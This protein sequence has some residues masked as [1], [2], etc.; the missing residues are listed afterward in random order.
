MSNFSKIVIIILIILSFFF[1]EEKYGKQMNS[2][3]SSIG[4]MPKIEMPNKNEETEQVKKPTDIS[5]QTNE[6]KNKTVANIYFLALDSD[7]NGILF[8]DKWWLFN[9]TIYY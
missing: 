2:L 4:T 7:D 8:F 6:T 9:E 5:N 1:I 3:L